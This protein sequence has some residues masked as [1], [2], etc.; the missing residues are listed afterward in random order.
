MHRAANAGQ[1]GS[2]SA[3]DKLTAF[4]PSTTHLNPTQRTPVAAPAVFLLGRRH[5]I[6]HA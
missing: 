1:N 2:R 5:P 6:P 4:G 3:F